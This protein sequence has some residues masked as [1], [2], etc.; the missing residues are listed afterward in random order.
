MNVVRLLLLKQ[1]QEEINCVMLCGKCGGLMVNGWL[2]ALK[3]TALPFE[4]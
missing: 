1:N 2:E 3:R 4:R